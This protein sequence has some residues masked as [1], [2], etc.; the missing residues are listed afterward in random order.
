MIGSGIFMLPAVLAPYGMMSFAG[1]IL[2]ASGSMCL[3]LVIARL[4]SRTRRSGGVYIYAREAF[5]DFVGF[6][7]AWGYW[8]S[9]W[10]SIPAIAIAFVGYLTVFVPAINTSPIYQAGTALALIWGLTAINLR[11]LK[12]AGF[13]Q[14]LMTVLKLLPLLLIIAW[15]MNTGSTANLPTAHPSGEPA[16]AALATTA[17]LT[18]WAFSGLEAGTM[19]AGDVINPTRTIPRAIVTGT[20]TV[21]FVYIASTYAVM[22]LVPA[23][24]LAL[25]T[26][27]FAEA[28]RALGAWGPGLIA[29]GAMIATAGS[30]NG[31]IF[32]TGQLPMAA[33]QDRLAPQ[34]LATRSADGVPR[35]ALILGSVLGS[36]LLMMNYSKGLIGM[37]TF[38]ATMSTLTILVPMFASAAAELKHSWS[39]AKAWALIAIFAAAYSLFAIIGSGF[40]VLI[41]GLALLAL[42][43]P[44]YLW[45]TRAT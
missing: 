2:T 20:L 21:A 42:G 31:I 40:T 7:I 33:A 14:T 5:G 30:L 29:I 12:S 8:C 28:A 4:A 19:P 6:L 13:V 32:V 35:L 3:A 22:R 27:P 37:F 45:L 24:Q 10:I 44:V 18:M 17:L 9:Y 34:W 36:L 11:S 43:I 38:L 26:A 39:I 15:G 23:D 1:W 41:M 25:S 16:L